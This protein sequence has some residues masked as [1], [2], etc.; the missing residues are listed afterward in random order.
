MTFLGIRTSTGLSV[1]LLLA[2]TA[3]ADVTAQDVWADWQAYMTGVGYE[4]TATET[5]SGDT[6]TVED[7]E[8]TAPDLGDGSSM[9]MRVERLDFREN[10]DG[11]VNVI[12]PETVAFDV[13]LKD[14]SASDVDIDMEIRTTAMDMVVTGVP[15]DMTSTYAAESI[16]MVMTGLTVDGEAVSNE[17]AAGRLLL[18]GLSGT[19]QSTVGGKRA[20]DQNMIAQAAA[21]EISFNDPEGSGD[22]DFSSTIDGLNFT[23]SSALPLAVVQA[24]DM[25]ALL[26]AGMTADG[27]F[28]YSGGA[29]KMSVVENGTPTFAAQTSSAGGT[30]NVTMGA[31]GLEYSGDQNELQVAMSG[32]QLPLPLALDMDNARFNLAMPLQKSEEMQDFAV[33]FAFN[34]FSMSEALWSIFDP[35]QQLPRDPATIVL[36]LAGKARLLFDFLDPSGAVM[37]GSPTVTPAEIDSVDINRLQISVAGAEL[38]GEGAF[39]FD[40]SAPDGP[41]KPTGA[42]D[43]TLTGANALID[44]LVGIGLLPEDQAMGARM[45]M[46]LL[47]VPGDEPDTLNS[48]IEIN[49]QGH[50]LANGQRIQ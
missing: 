6:L 32:D 5:Q 41:P 9:V 34:D 17:D 3:Q 26:A 29:S 11:S 31:E 39:T 48:K 50:V 12:Y 7:I 33:G 44:K 10:D 2:G 1:A 22:F 18:S 4:M 30:L 47:A 42:A 49:D 13:E 20:Y 40:N 45:M 23:G 15:T 35:G 21:Y 43:L 37:S 8:M 28:G 24:T 46:G 25:S 27:T 38:N 16:E 19:T 14:P 36:D